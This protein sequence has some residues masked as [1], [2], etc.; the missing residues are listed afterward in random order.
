MVQFKEGVYS[1]DEVVETMVVVR[2]AVSTCS[3]HRATQQSSEELVSSVSKEAI[4][5]RALVA[6]RLCLSLS[7]LLILCHDSQGR[8]FFLFWVKSEESEKELRNRVNER[9]LADRLGQL[10]P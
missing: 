7:L 4:N 5:L 6:S 10:A 2:G 1:G 3:R 8:F 9:V